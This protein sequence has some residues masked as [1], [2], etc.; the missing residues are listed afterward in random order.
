MC[1]TS[2]RILLLCLL[3]GCGVGA[4]SVVIHQTLQPKLSTLKLSKVCLEKGSGTDECP[5]DQI[6]LTSDTA[7]PAL[8]TKVGA[9]IGS[10]GYH[11]VVHS[12]DAGLTIMVK[13]DVDRPAYR[14]EESQQYYPEKCLRFEQRCT[15]GPGLNRCLRSARKLRK[16]NARKKASDR[17]REVHRSCSRVCVSLRKAYTEYR[18]SE[19]CR[20]RLNLDVRRFVSRTGE[21]VGGDSGLSLGQP[22]F[23]G[24]STSRLIQKNQKPVAV[25]ADTMCRRAFDN[26]V[27][28]VS[29]W[30]NPSKIH[31]TYIFADL[32]AAPYR[33]ALLDLQFGRYSNAHVQLDE[34]FRQAA[35]LGLSEKEVAWVHHA[36]AAVFY[37]QEDVEQ[38]TTQLRLAAGLNSEL[39]S[40]HGDPLGHSQTPY[41][42][43][44]KLRAK[45][46][47]HGA[48]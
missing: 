26:A 23:D 25:G 7:S 21:A 13:V 18:L 24:E 30:F 12:G 8:L 10:A 6:L 46:S 33:S 31:T 36:K 44:R 3:S 11:D 39:S 42:T 41:G 2:L 4:R 15:N 16:N 22:G 14:G 19:V 28:Q 40:L 1:T 20:S 43:Y 32:E 48:E 5:G 9:V 17:C 27:A 35:L 45:C 47:T 38:C 37:L 34:T 29:P